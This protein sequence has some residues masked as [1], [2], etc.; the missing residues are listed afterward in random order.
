MTRDAFNECRRL[1]HLCGNVHVR[2]RVTPKY[3]PLGKVRYVLQQLMKTMRN[4]WI[5]GKRITIDESMI[6]YCGRAVAF[7]QYMPKNLSSMV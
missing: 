2:H 5:V 4:G 6:K 3:D 1:I 7:I